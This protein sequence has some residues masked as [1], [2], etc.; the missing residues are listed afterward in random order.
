M[1]LTEVPDDP[2]RTQLLRQWHVP[3]SDETDE[4]MLF[5]DLSFDKASYDNEHQT[6]NEPQQFAYT[7]NC[8]T[9]IALTEVVDSWKSA[10]DQKQYTISVFLDLRKA[11]DVIDHSVLLAK[12]KNY[13]LGEVEVNWI[14]SYLTDRQQY[15]VHKNAK[16]DIEVITKGVPQGSVLGPTFCLYVNT[17]VSSFENCDSILYADDTEIHYSDKDLSTARTKVN[18]DMTNV[19]HWL[20]QNRMI[21]NVKKTKA[22]LIGSRQTIK[23]AEKIK[24][25]LNNKTI[26]QVTTFDYLGVRVNNDL[27]WEPHISRLCQR[28]GQK[29]CCF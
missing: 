8:S 26:E 22:M 5:E 20:T 10:I 4:A 24:I 11:F 12:L 21:A 18:Q 19:D 25:H 2:T 13:G 28:T 23:K 9:T 6:L 3:R 17:I 29:G 1:E 14:S 16:S 7:K 15:V 27:S